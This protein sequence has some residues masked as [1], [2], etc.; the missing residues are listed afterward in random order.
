MDNINAA[1]I[2]AY[3]SS[4]WA[5]EVYELQL[6]EELN[7]ASGAINMLMAENAVPDVE[8][9]PVEGSAPVIGNEPSDQE[10]ELEAVPGVEAVPV[11]G[12]T[13]VMW[14]TVPVD[15]PTGDIFSYEPSD[16]E[17]ELEMG[18]MAPDMR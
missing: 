16:Q 18:P 6:E 7:M 3:Y 17:W 8:A 5:A 14:R 12:S 9:A 10:W 11:E 15:V 1:D 13:P 2:A 4:G